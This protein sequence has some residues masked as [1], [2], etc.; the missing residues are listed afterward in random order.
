MRRLAAWI[1]GLVLLS[2]FPA[3]YAAA[4]GGVGELSLDRAAVSALVAVA[5]EG[6]HDVE[7]PGVGAVSIAIDRPRRLE[8]R[9]GG[10]EAEL[11]VR[12]EAIDLTFA[13]H[14]RYV[15]QVE[16]K[17]GNVALR[18]ETV[19]PVPRLPLPVDLSELLPPV[20]LPRRL[21]WELDLP[22]GNRADVTCFVQSLV[23]DEDR[24]IVGLG[25]V[26]D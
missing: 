4:A 23:V 6:S 1:I 13:F 11:P 9:D 3:S 25:L 17:S 7:L 14:V 8:F 26:L 21:D 2:V 12:V 5:V 20:S 16:P 22:D 15:P 19:R 10:V 18:A 24:L